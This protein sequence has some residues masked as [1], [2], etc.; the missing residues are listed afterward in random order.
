[1]EKDKLRGEIKAIVKSN[2]RMYHFE[3]YD[4]D[5]ASTVATD[6]ILELIEKKDGK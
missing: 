5:T 6:E 4:C 3:E 2:I 1:M